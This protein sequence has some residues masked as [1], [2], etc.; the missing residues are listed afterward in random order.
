VAAVTAMAAFAYIAFQVLAADRGGLAIVGARIR[1][2]RL[3]AAADAG[4]SLGLHGLAEDNPSNRWSIDGRAR[5]V[6]FDGVDLAIVAEDERGKAPLAGLNDAQARALFAG[7]GADGAR[8][9]ALVAEFRDWQT[10]DDRVRNG[11]PTAAELAA[12]PIRH[13]PIATVGELAGLKDMDPSLLARIAPV[14]TVFFEESGPFE[15]RNAKPLAIAA[16]SA[17]SGVDAAAAATQPDINSQNPDEEITPDDHLVGRTITL[18]VTARDPDGA[19]TH[20][21]AIVELTGD[22]ARPYWIRYVE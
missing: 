7:A 14:V 15:P 5:H 19:Q 4:I 16:M 12:P 10:E 18:R 2:A 3:A 9:D 17:Q 6:D 13:G 22:K 11:P 1:Q 20:R 8:L 21:M